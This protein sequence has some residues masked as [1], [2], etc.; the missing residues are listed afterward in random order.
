MPNVATTRWKVLGN[1]TSLEETRCL[2]CLLALS[3]CQTPCLGIC[4]CERDIT[5]CCLL[6]FFLPFKLAALFP[7]VEWTEDTNT[8]RGQIPIIWK[9]RQSHHVKCNHP[10]ILS[11][12]KYTSSPTL[13]ISLSTLKLKVILFNQRI[14][15][16][17]LFQ[18]TQQKP[19]SCVQS[20]V[21]PV[22][23]TFNSMRWVP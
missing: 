10:T 3:F 4:V 16:I 12:V 21:F 15:I 11:S 5:L 17:V 7:K 1:E 22:T 8:N 9:K 20:Q 13:G 14:Y 18:K 23:T 2:D 6:L 19:Y